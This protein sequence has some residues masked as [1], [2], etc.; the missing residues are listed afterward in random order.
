MPLTRVSCPFGLH[1]H[2]GAREEV[3]QEVLACQRDALDHLPLG[4]QNNV[5]RAEI[6]GWIDE[7]ER[8]CRVSGQISFRIG[9]K[10]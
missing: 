4:P 7:E 9:S 2:S 6:E 3:V 8:S 10:S 1:F 5:T